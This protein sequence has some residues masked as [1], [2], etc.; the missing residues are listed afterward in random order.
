MED[1]A[2]VTTSFSKNRKRHKLAFFRSK[3]QGLVPPPVG[4]WV[5]DACFRLSIALLAPS[6]FGHGDGLRAAGGGDEARDRCRTLVM[7]GVNGEKDTPPNLTWIRWPGI[8]LWD[9]ESGHS[10]GRNAFQIF[11]YFQCRMPCGKVNDPN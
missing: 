4:E 11:M 5:V 2:D 1:H 3:W 6:W 8:D 9:D 10:E 7:P